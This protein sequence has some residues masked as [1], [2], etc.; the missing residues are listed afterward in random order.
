MAA[1]IQ[2]LAAAS[3]SDL[4]GILCRA[5]CTGMPDFISQHSIQ[6]ARSLR[7]KH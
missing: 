1:L 2:W 7:F 5:C 3:G 4:C 6:L